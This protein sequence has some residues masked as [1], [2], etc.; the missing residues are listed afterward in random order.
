MHIFFVSSISAVA[1]WPGFNP[2]ST[3]NTG[4]FNGIKDGP[5]ASLGDL[6][7]NRG[8][9][10]Y[11]SELPPPTSRIPSKLGYAQS[12]YTAERLLTEATITHNLRA[13]IMRPGQIS[14]AKA[15]PGPLGSQNEWFPQLLWSS[16][17]MGIL[18][19]TVTR[20][21]M[22]DFIPVDQLAVIIRDI[23]HASFTSPARNNN[24]PS[25]FNLVNPDAVPFTDLIPAVQQYFIGK[26]IDE[27]KIVPLSVWIEGLRRESKA[28]TGQIVQDTYPALKIERFF[29]G[30]A[31]DSTDEEARIDTA[32]GCSI[33]NTM[34]GLQSI[35]GDDIST[36]LRDWAM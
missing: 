15:V 31:S 26:G 19:Q 23:V 17:H 3:A 34:R 33:S 30:L 7:T 11:V 29:E 6:A 32:N 1:H 20:T 22:I 13:T 5:T 24:S 9:K 12:K 16:K 14:N 21:G 27:I 8:H 2:S 35:T 10:I 25:I 36:W 18:P 28:N 4:V